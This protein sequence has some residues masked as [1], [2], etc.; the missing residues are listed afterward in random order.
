VTDIIHLE[1]KQLYYYKGNYD[2]FKE[3]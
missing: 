2:D 1:D 3:M